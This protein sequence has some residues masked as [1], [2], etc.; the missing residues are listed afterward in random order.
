MVNR[1]KLS[2]Q[3]YLGPLMNLFF[4]AAKQGI[5]V[6]VAC[7]GVASPLLQQAADITNGLFVQVVTLL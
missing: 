1:I 4:S 5:C 2:Q 3:P 7:M 6:D